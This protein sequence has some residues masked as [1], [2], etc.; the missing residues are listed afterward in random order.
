MTADEHPLLSIHR[1]TLVDRLV[2]LL[3]E[4]IFSG[5]RLPKTKISEAGVAKEFGVSRI[6]AREALQRLEEMKLVRKTHLGR[7]IAQ[8]SRIE[9]EQIYELK[10]VV[11]AFGAMKGSLN[12]D[13][14][15]MAAI[16]AIL[17]S[18]HAVIAREDIKRL[19]ILNYEFHDSLVLSCH[20]QRIIDTFLSLVNQIRWAMPFSLRVP[21]RPVLGYREHRKIFSAFRKR[22]AEKVRYLLET[23]SN[24]NMRRILAQMES[25]ITR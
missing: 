19:Q 3:Q 22:D 23:H 5:K 2:Q 12:A 9:F 11:E 7:E 6:P 15:E 20:N 24:A 25:Q 8:V 16:E 21:Q 1:E 13:D 10:N 17:N 4:S 18:M 14:A